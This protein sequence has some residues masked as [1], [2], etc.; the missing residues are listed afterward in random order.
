VTGIVWVVQITSPVFRFH[1]KS[2]SSNRER[3]VNT[4][5][6]SKMLASIAGKEKTFRTITGG[7]E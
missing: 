4:A 3:T 2:G 5:S 7:T 1:H 6:T